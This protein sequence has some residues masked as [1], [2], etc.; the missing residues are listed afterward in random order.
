MYFRVLLFWNFSYN[1]MLLFGLVFVLFCKI[2]LIFLIKPQFFGIWR[3]RRTR[4]IKLVPETG[5][6]YT[7]HIK[8]ISYHVHHLFGIIYSEKH[9]FHFYT[10][11][12]HW[13]ARISVKPSIQRNMPLG[14]M[15]YLAACNLTYCSIYIIFTGRHNQ[16]EIVKWWIA[17]IK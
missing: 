13:T 12:L 8:I 7:F 4:N 11:A 17:T 2:T 16:M 10:W 5:N 15:K 3:L 9:Y 14:S 1:K 6:I